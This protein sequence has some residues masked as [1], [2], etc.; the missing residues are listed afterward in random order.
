[1]VGMA[2]M[3]VCRSQEGTLIA[4]GLGSCIGICAY[5]ARAQ[6]S[7]M[8]HV[9]LPES[10]P[11]TTQTGKFADTAV[12]LLI[13]RMVEMGANKH[14]IRVVLA[15]GAQLFVGTQTGARMD[16]GPR[17]AAAVKAALTKCGICLHAEDLGGNSG[18]T[19]TLLKDGTVRVKV[20]GK[21]EKII[22]SLSQS[23]SHYGTTNPEPFL[24]RAA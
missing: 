3:A 16:V 13:Q 2:E 9:V 21:G 1:M 23:A 19:V 10:S 6:I 7:G 8:S 4:L 24:Q 22:A 12:P 5:D 18:R 17:N 14:S 11:N 20:L 15:G